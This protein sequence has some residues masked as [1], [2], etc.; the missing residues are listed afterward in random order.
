MLKKRV[1]KSFWAVGLSAIVLFVSVTMNFLPDNTVTIAAQQTNNDSMFDSVLKLIS[2]KGASIVKDNMPA[3][4]DFLCAQV[5]DYLGI[6]YRDSYTKEISEINDKLS[7]INKNLAEIIKNQNKMESQNTMIDFLNN[8]DVFSSAVYPI[9]E[10]YA[11]LSVKESDSGLLK[12]EVEQLEEKFYNQSLSKL[13]FGSS[14]STGDLYLQL[15][16]LLDKITNP[17]RT[18]NLSL[19]E[20]Y[21]VTYEHLWAFDTQSFEPKREFLEYVSTVAM[22]GLILYTFQNTY[23]MKFADELQEVEYSRKW[24][25]IKNSAQ[26]AFEYLQKEIN[27]LDELEKKRNDTNTVLH[28]STGNILSKDMYISKFCSDSSHYTY[29]SSHSTTR[30]GNMRTVRVFAL[31]N[32]SFI[33]VIQKEFKEYKKN[34]NK[35]NDF[36][37]S[38]FLKSAGFKCSDWNHSLYRSQY[39]KHEGTT[40]TNEYYKFYVSYLNRNG[41][42]T[43]ST[44]WTQ[45]VYKVLGSPTPKKNDSKDWSYMAFVDENGVLLGSYDEIYDDNGNTTVDA[46]YSMVRGACAKIP[47]TRGKVR[48]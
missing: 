9:Y 21:T 25:E 20:H 45:L 36:L 31:N 3:V 27:V 13:Y 24:K 37:V 48:E 11:A 8:V 7:Q 2:E 46:I 41:N 40:I 29:A 15:K 17:N 12:Q 4:G 39:M 22:E 18:S 33:D 30:Q 38:D 35:G 42:D 44:Q 28:Y 26:N 19:M 5:F 16:V 43:D 10:S 14:S 32:N 34:Y 6:D 1:L 23:Q 47:S